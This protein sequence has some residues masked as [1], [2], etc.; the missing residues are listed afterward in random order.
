MIL[1]QIDSIISQSNRVLDPVFLYPLDEY[2][3]TMIGHLEGDLSP[4][5]WI[6]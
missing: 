6:F 4:T 5:R 3:G 2:L 1:S